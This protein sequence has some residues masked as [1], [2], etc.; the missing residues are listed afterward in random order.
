MQVWKT[1]MNMGKT[2]GLGEIQIREHTNTAA[3]QSVSLRDKV[4]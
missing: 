4:V 2:V 3:K 1:A